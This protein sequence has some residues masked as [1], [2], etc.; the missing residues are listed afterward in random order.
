MT[1]VNTPN[2]QTG[3]PVE[4]QLSGVAWPGSRCTQ[5]ARPPRRAAAGPGRGRRSGAAVRR[6]PGTGGSRRALLLSSRG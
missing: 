5:L 3:Q 6:C 2:E 1:E 4:P